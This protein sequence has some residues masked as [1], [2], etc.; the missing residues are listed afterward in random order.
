MN[1]SQ[2]I[3]ILRDASAKLGPNSYCGPWLAGVISEVESEIR[4]DFMPSPTLAATQRQCDAMLESMK[5]ECASLRESAQK[6]CVELRRKTAQ[7]DS[8]IR[9][10][11][12]SVLRRSLGVI[13]GTV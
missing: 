1:K 5:A 4:S 11:T 10:S 12:A 2:E 13:S 3:G 6:E 7:W 9:E 8:S